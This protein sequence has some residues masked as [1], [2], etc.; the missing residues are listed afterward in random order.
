MPPKELFVPVPLQAK[1]APHRT[2]FYQKQTDLIAN[3]VG[4]NTRGLPRH[5]EKETLIGHQS[6]QLRKQILDHFTRDNL[7]QQARQKDT[8]K[9]DRIQ[10]LQVEIE[11]IKRDREAGYRL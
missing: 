9:N 10:E 11:T 1:P 4:E 7:E 6:L 8:V 5:S 3:G 2:P